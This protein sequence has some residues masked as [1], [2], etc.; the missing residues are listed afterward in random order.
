VKSVL[1]KFP[2]KAFAASVNREKI[3]K[4]E[5]SLNV[6]LDQFVGWVLEAMQE[7]ADLLGL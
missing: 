1:K 4:C 3:R 5:E 7:E 6:P 2:A